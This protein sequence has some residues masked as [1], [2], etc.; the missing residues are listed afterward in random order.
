[1]A[2]A[3]AKMGRPKKII[4]KEQFE[5]LC[6]MQCIQTEICSVLKVTEKT[7][8]AWCKETYGDTFSNTIKRFSEGGKMSLRRKQLEVAINGNVTMLIWLGKQYLGQRD[9]TEYTENIASEKLDSL[10]EQ[11]DDSNDQA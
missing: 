3:Q 11:L 7:L 10:L 8:I 4:D 5:T 6:E 1:M 9:K 2:E